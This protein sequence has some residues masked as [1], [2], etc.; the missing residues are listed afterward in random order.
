[1]SL[2]VLKP[3]VPAPFI[4]LLGQQS[5]TTLRPAQEKTIKAG[6]FEGQNILICTPTASGKT[7]SAVF[8]ILQALKD[9]KKAIYAVPLKALASEKFE[10]LK[11]YLNPLGATVAMTVGD[12]DTDGQSLSKADVIVCSN[13]KLDSLIRHHAPWLNNV[14]CLIIDEVHLLNDVS[15]GPTLEILITM[16]KQLVKPLQIIALSATVQNASALADWLEAVLIKD[17]WRPVKLYTGIMHE[18]TI[19]FFDDKEHLFIKGEAQDPTTNIVIDAIKN[20]KQTLVFVSTKRST[21]AQAKKI[22]TVATTKPEEQPI[23]DE[24]AKKVRTAVSPPTTQCLELSGVIKHGVAFHHSGLHPKQRTIVEELFKKRRIKAICATPTLAIGINMPAFRSIVRDLK[25]YTNFGLDW[26]PVLE[27]QQM[28]G[29]SGRPGYDEFGEAIC[30]AGTEQQKEQIYNKYLKGEPEP[31]L[32]KIAVEPVLRTYL[33]S[34]IAIEFITT[35]KE[36]LAFFG[37]TFWAFQYGNM[38]ELNQKIEKMLELLLTFKFLKQEKNKYSATIIGK[39]VATLYLDPVTADKLIKG[40]KKADTHTTSPFA[41]IQLIMH[42]PEAGPLPSI[43]KTDLLD[44][45]YAEETLLDQEVY[46]ERFLPS[47]KATVIADE[48]MDEVPERDLFER[49]G[50]APGL[51]HTMRTNTEWLL[52]ALKELAKLTSYGDLNLIERTRQRVRYGVKEELLPLVRLKGVGRVRARRLFMRGFK[53]SGAIRI[54]DM[55]ILSELIGRSVAVSLKRQ[56]GVNKVYPE[57]LSTKS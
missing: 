15:R 14:S 12:Y 8:G 4:E 20:E 45:V 31:I 1:M 21:Q 44:D 47:I 48:W 32:S 56:L 35:K 41:I 49:Y 19:D 36:I 22:A 40:L 6:V 16:L 53:T 3:F 33:L 34:L 39:R 43:R 7:L 2:Q 23:L 11:G 24:A 10:S 46:D 13:E 51:L 25:R 27:V 54:A 42:T 17:D 26:L 18:R 30:L 29:R 55:K 57:P 5:I 37:K 38:D 52:Y 9:G 28:F 50:T